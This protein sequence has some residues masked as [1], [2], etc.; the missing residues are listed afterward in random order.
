LISPTWTILN[1]GIVVVDID[2]VMMISDVVIDRNE[3]PSFDLGTFHW[4][5]IKTS[6]YIRTAI[7]G[8]WTL[9]NFV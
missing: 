8:W 9:L 5:F 1:D 7:F 4:W 3:L 2:V 6:L